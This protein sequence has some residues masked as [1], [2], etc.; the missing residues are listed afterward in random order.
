VKKK[1]PNRQEIIS[2]WLDLYPIRQYQYE[3]S[4]EGIITVLVPHS[5]NWLTKKILPK[6]KNPAQ[7][8]HLDELG[9][10]VWNF[11]DGK[12]SVREICQNLEKEFKERADS[13]QER[14]VLFVQ[15]MYQQNFIKVYSKSTPENAG[16]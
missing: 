7:R 15:Q 13:V 2:Q 16:K 4:Q 6:P 8:I 11:C 14:T 12:Y 5:E 9:S 10:F 1:K 3:T